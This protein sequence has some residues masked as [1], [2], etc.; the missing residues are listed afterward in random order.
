[1]ISIPPGK[2][3]A[4]IADPPWSYGTYS[5]K[6]KGRAAEAYYD[7]MD[8]A[9]IKA[10]PVASWAA[11]DSVLFLWVHNS[12]L[13]EALEVMQAW[14]FA[15]KSR[16]FTWIKTYP[17]KDDLFPRPPRYA[18][19]LGYWTRLSTELCLLGARGRPSRRA[20]DVRELIVSP[21]GA[22]SEKPAEIHELIER[23]APGPYLEL[24]GGRAP[25]RDGWTQG[26][27][28]D[29]APQR[30]WGSSSYPGEVPVSQGGGG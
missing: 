8:L 30:R 11:P 18:V 13:P 15:Y 2:F 12:M 19:G 3:A 21:R 20:R 14:G 5:A 16:G 6:G 4:I 17:E 24:F 22:H 27:A 28:K 26:L 7:T 29:L 1:V 9:A 10:V 25:P 23:L